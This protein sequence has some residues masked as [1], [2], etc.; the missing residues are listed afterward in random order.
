M[1]IVLAMSLPRSLLEAQ[2]SDIEGERETKC[3]DAMYL[4]QFCDHTALCV[5]VYLQQEVWI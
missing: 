3:T 4:L 2:P 5:V 1:L